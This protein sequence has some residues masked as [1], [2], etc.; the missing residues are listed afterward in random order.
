MPYKIVEELRA[1]RLEAYALHERC[2][3][4]Q[5]VKVLKTIG[6]DRSYERA[7]GAYLFDTEGNR[8]LDLLSGFGVFALGRSHPGIKRTLQEILELDLPN[9]VQMD[10]SVLSGLLA[11]KL[12]Q[13]CPDPIDRAFFANSGTE[14][15]E[16]AIKFSRAATG[17]SVMVHCAHA[18]HGLSYGALSL[19]GDRIFQDG[20]G[21]MLAGCREIPFNNLMALEDALKSKDVACFVVEPIQGKGVYVPDAGYLAEAARL[22]RRHGTLLVVDEIQTGLGRT[23]R[24]FAFEHEDV[25]PDIITAAKALSGGYVP[26]GVVLTKTAIFKKLFDRMDRAV[27]HGSTFGKN[28]LAMAAGLATLGALD[29]EQLVQKAHVRGLALKTKLQ[30]LVDKYEMVKAVHGRGLMLGI[31]FGP[32]KSL[33]LK[34]A[35]ALLDKANPG[36]FCQMITIPLFK[37]HR[38]ISQVA[39]HGSYVV[40]LL[41]PLVI[42][43]EDVLH[44]ATAFDDVIQEAHR[45]PGAVWDLATTLAGHALSNKTAQTR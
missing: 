40:K 36:L 29:E 9:L 28:N 38:I 27:V 42:S 24:F 3:N 10:C 14:A 6:F 44:V 4:A 37:K 7:E 21:P 5:F 45:F 12:L 35:W 43:E 20:L 34:A 33:S 41:P 13:K 8:Y 11:E 2:L 26:V 30:E 32:P 1:R 39:G 16:A 22:C 31:E 23:G 18:F 15:V 25:V 17:R 19:G